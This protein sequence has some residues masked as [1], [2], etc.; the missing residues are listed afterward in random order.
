MTQPKTILTAAHAICPHL[1]TLLDAETAQQVDRELRSLLI[2]AEAGQS[3]ETS[4]T[5]VLRQ[6][7]PTQA[8]MRRYLKG[9]TPDQ[10]TRS[11]Q[12]PS[13]NAAPSPATTTFKCPHCDYTDT[14]PQ[15]GM[16]PE[17]CPN[18]PNVSLI[19]A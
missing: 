14:V 4:I 15:V 5:E 11:M 16:I 1:A 8:W 17:P 6:H 9:E 12:F 19:A 3:V 7:E 10:I 18:H 13:G 2:Q